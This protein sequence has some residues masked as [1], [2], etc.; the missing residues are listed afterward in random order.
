MEVAGVIIGGVGLA[1][2]FDTCMNTFEYVDTGKKYG[3]DY[4]KAALKVSVLELRLSRWGQQVQFSA[5]TAR[6]PS[7]DQVEGLLGQIQMDLEDACKA[8]KRYVLPASKGMYQEGVGSVS[9]ESLGDRFRSLSLKRQKRTSLIKKTLWALRDK[10]KLDGLISDIKASVDSLESLYPAIKSPSREQR[11]AVTEDVEQLVQPSEIEEPGEDTGPIIAVLREVTEGVDD[12][13][14]EAVDLAA[15][16]VVSGDSFKNI[17]TSDRAKVMF[18][19]Y[20]A[21]GYT[22]SVL[23]ERKFTQT[24]NNMVTTDDAKVIIGNSHGGKGFWDD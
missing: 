11:Q 6:N 2:L 7:A 8:S 18:G 9:L 4:Q 10:R 12:R 24:V 22:G 1:A 14:H 5:T 19:G 15:A 23:E 16:Q 13:L 3:V 20:V 17:F 21:S